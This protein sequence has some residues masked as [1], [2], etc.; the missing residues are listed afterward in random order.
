[1]NHE[2]TLW[3]QLRHNVRDYVDVALFRQLGYDR[4]GP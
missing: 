4:T 2:W 3:D 1:M